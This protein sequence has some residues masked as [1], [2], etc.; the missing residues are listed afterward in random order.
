[1]ESDARIAVRSRILNFV[2]HHPRDAVGFHEMTAELIASAS[3][4]DVEWVRDRVQDAY[5][6]FGYIVP[7]S[8][9]SRWLASIGRRGYDDD[10]GVPGPH[11][12]FCAFDIETRFS[13]KGRISHD[14]ALDALSAGHGD[15]TTTWGLQVYHGHQRPWIADSRTDLSEKEWNVRA[16]KALKHIEDLGVKTRGMV[17]G[18]VDVSE[19]AA[20]RPAYADDALDFR[21]VRSYPPIEDTSISAAPHA[22]HLDG[23]STPIYKAYVAAL[24][25]NAE[26]AK[27]M[28]EIGAPLDPERQ[29]DIAEALTEVFRLSAEID[30]YRL[31]L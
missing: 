7:P 31:K 11:P 17:E 6:E 9:V 2:A 16:N 12:R 8:G 21:V 18:L 13:E 19:P 29:K 27:R 20:P 28:E 23:V 3:P 1:M 30:A 26:N 24:Q 4:K 15:G 25:R 5:V 14:E 10:E 22:Y